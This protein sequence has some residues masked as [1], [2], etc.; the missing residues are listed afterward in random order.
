MKTDFCPEISAKVNVVTFALALD[1]T[2]RTFDKDG[3]L[4]IGRSHISKACVNPYFGRE[5]PGSEALGLD[6]EKVYYLFRSPD[7]LEKAAPTF[8]RLPILKKHIPV[9]A[10]SPRQDLIVGAIGSE[11]EFLAPYLDADVC[12]WDEKA[13]AGIETDQVREFSCA[14]HYVPIMTTG[15]F[16]GEHFDGIMTQ[17][18]G[19]HL[20]L[21]ESGRAG[22]DVIAADSKL[23][24]PMKKTKLGKALFIALTTAFP[25]LKIAEDSELGKSLASAARKTFDKPGAKKLILAMDADVPDEQVSAVM[26]ALVDV[27]DPEPTRK[28]NEKEEK[29]GKDGKKAKDSDDDEE[30]EEETEE[31]K[32]K[33]EARDKK[34][35]DKAAKDV[36]CREKE[37][38]GAMD[39]M[40]ADMRAAEQAKRDVRSVVGDVIAQDSAAEIYEFALDHL[41]IDHKGVEGIPALSA[42]FKVAASKTNTEPA[43]IGMDSASMAAAKTRFPHFDRVVQG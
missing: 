2:A 36:E 22:S 15:T 35:K 38:K 26:D 29:A 12:I 21:V 1:A 28:D 16:E 39:A 14:Y 19:N 5:I 25:K 40:R 37:V 7:E 42:L 10:E 8:A 4:H 6:S 9:T 24:E 32:K 3:R 34:A 23:G 30:T 17:I 18:Q 27:D 11:V 33:R 20:A 13:I 41:K 43:F 31:E